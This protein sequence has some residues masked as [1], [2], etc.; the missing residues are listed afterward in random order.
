MFTVVP[1]VR[2]QSLTTYQECVDYARTHNITLQQS[3]LTEQLTAS[4]LEAA[5]AQWQPTLDFG[6]AH[7]YSN[8]PWGNG[9][10]NTFGGNF[11]LSA[12]WTV[13][14]GGVRRN[15]I[16]LNEKQQQIDALATAQT[17]RT[18][19]TDLLSVYL[20]ILYASESIDIYKET[21][22]LSQAQVDRARGLMEAGKLSRVDFAQLNAQL[23]QDN[24]NLV[25]ARSQ[26]ATRR[27]ELK[28]LLQLGITDSIT[29][30]PL[31]WDALDILTPLPPIDE[32]YRLATQTDLMLQSLALQKD[33][34]DINISIAKAG[35]APRID[36]NAGVGTAYTVPGDGFGQQL[37]QAMSEHIGVSLAI[38]IFDQKK[39]KTA[40]TKANI[41]KLSVDLDTDQRLLDLSQAVES[42]YVDVNE[43]LSRYQ[44]ATE[45]EK[46]A[47]LS[48]DLINE[49]FTLGLVNPVELLTA[50]NTLLEARHS[51]LQAKYMALLGRKMIEYYRTAE[52]T[53]P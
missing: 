24:Y 38:P 23:E 31:D 33:A 40:V 41:E 1:V 45:Q 36:L 52:I 47:A 22:E 43:A 50:H 7:T 46:S 15:T 35:H 27:M 21:V 48:N 11:N 20:N 37:R 28:K 39:T 49:R 17:L 26:Y 8:A 5:K 2:S 13:Y 42:W 32:S 10:R 29:P 4:S 19:E 44:A 14:N 16:K 18:I 30:A 51:V 9:N 3:Q 34:A 12:G 25:N 53:L 6:T